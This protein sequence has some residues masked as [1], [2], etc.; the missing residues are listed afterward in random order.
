MPSVNALQVGCLLSE[1][2][3]KKFAQTLHCV[4]SPTAFTI[5]L[6]YESAISG[7]HSSNSDLAN[8]DSYSRNAT[9]CSNVT[10]FRFSGQV[11]GLHPIGP[12]V[13]PTTVQ[14]AYPRVSRIVPGGTI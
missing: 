8:P 7:L 14:P 5:S 4:A 1:P 12:D 2:A 9:I 6:A 10:R 11:P 3:S 13:A